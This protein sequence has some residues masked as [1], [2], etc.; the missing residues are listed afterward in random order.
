MQKYEDNLSF[1]EDG[2]LKGVIETELKKPHRESTS[3]CGFF[4]SLLLKIRQ[5]FRHAFIRSTMQATSSS[6]T[7]GPL[8]RHKPRLNKA[9]LTP[10]T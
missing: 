8:G 4:S 1:T 3:R 10:F 6:V 9:S 2:V 7:H 5:G